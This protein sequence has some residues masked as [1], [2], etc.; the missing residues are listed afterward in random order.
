MTPGPR[1]GEALSRA[2]EGAI[3]GA[4]PNRKDDL[5]AFVGL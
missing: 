1:V 2:L 5:L 3:V 4:V